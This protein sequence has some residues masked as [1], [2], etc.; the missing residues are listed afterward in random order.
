MPHAVHTCPACTGRWRVQCLVKSVVQLSQQCCR[1]FSYENTIDIQNIFNLLMIPS[2]CIF[3]LLELIQ[4][5]CAS[6]HCTVVVFLWSL[7][8]WIE[9]D[10][11]VVVGAAFHVETTFLWESIFFFWVLL[12]ESISIFV[13]SNSFTNNLTVITTI[14]TFTTTTMTHSTNNYAVPDQLL[15]SLLK[16]WLLWVLVLRILSSL[17]CLYSNESI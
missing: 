1:S 9:R 17:L 14:S 11:Q 6:Y 13:H 4:H 3:P 2:R 5:S 10:H 8:V 16:V 15:V 12:C 7:P